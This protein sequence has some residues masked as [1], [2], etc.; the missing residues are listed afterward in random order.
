[1]TFL[2]IVL[3]LHHAGLYVLRAGV[4]DEESTNVTLQ[5]Y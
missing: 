3:A 4:S 1:M 5:G 2:C